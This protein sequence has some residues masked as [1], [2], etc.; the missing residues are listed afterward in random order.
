MDD[1]SNLVYIVFLVIYLLSRVLG[2][3]KK[4]A[5]RKP[6]RKAQRHDEFEIPNEPTGKQESETPRKPSTFEEILR[7]FQRGFEGKEQSEESESEFD[8][9]ETFRGAPRKPLKEKYDNEVEEKFEQAIEDAGKIK[10]LDEQ[11]DIE[12]FEVKKPKI[13]QEAEASRETKSYY[14]K[15]LSNPQGARDAVILSE[16]LNRKYS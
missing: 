5:T 10:T 12:S 3:K 2:N 16:I 8:E 4:P 15:L 7:E 1:I 6:P 11:I 14:A 13:V 9:A